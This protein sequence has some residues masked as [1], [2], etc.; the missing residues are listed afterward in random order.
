MFPAEEFEKTV[1]EI[2]DRD[3][4]NSFPLLFNTITGKAVPLYNSK[5]QH[6]YWLLPFLLHDKIRG[7]AIFDLN[8][9]VVS[10]GVLMPNVQ[11][12]NKLP[13]KR[14]FDAVPLKTVQEIEKTYQAD[15]VASP[16]LAYDETPRKWG[17]MLTL[18]KDENQR[19]IFIGPQGWYEKK[20][21]GSRE[22]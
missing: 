8:A 5:K 14:F 4:K 18:K 13:D 9:Q 3:L 10:H 21:I 20:E 16:F 6:Q 1:S 17:W 2:I 15:V 19:V 11:D 7:I 12:E 22:G